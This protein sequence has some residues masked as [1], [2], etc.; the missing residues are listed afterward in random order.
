M[1][2]RNTRQKQVILNI[3]SGT[4]SHPTADWIYEEARKVL[5]KISKGTVY[6]NLKVLSQSGRITELKIDKSARRYDARGHIHYHLK[7]EN[8]DNV[9]DLE[10]PVRKDLDNWASEK[11]GIAVNGHNIEFFGLCR[12]CLAKINR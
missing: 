6:R 7:C 12:G 1:A 5:P 3:L 11:A 8:C 10:V 2:S 4:T 9:Y